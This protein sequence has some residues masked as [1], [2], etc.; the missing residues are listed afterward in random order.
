MPMAFTSQILSTSIS[1]K[2]M[3]E[4]YIPHTVRSVSLYHSERLKKTPKKSS[5]IIITGTTRR[6]AQ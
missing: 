1:T 5:A 4:K 3:S 6:P 2:Q